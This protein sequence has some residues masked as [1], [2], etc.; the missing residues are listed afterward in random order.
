M[1]GGPGPRAG[2]RPAR[3]RAGDDARLGGIPAGRGREPRQATGPGRGRR[4]H[5]RRGARR[6]RDGAAGRL[7]ARGGV[8]DRPR[9]RQ[10]RGGGVALRGPAPAAA[11][12]T[13]DRC[14][15]LPF[16]GIAVELAALDGDIAARAGR[17]PM[18]GRRMPNEDEYAFYARELYLPALRAEADAAE[19]ARA[20]RDA[21]A[22]R[23]RRRMFARWPRAWSAGGGGRHEGTAAPGRG[24]PGSRGGRG[25]ARGGPR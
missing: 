5:D 15:W 10:L 19:R 17:W 3:P 8:S 7:R 20:G 16:Y 12:R 25:S 2:G 1:R 24:G 11:P 13:P 21:E 18:P 6:R 9:E 23:R 14:G 4:A 22:E